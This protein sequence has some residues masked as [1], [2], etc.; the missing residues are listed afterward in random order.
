MRI[1]INFEDR[2]VQKKSRVI[3]C[4]KRD[5]KE[6][7]V[8]NSGLIY[9]THKSHLDKFISS[10]TKEDPQMELHMV[11]VYKAREPEGTGKGYWCPYCCN[12]EYWVSDMLSSKICPIC[13]ISDNDFYVKSYNKLF[14][15]KMESKSSQ[16]KRERVKRQVK[17]AQDKR[18]AKQ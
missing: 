16:V 6:R 9:F 3:A 15:K 11:D 17:K 18:R 14:D 7:I 10:I 12:W 1:S 2:I 8:Y 4:I 13:G 5:H